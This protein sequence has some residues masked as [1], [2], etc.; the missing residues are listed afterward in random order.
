MNTILVLCLIALA[1]SLDYSIG[2]ITLQAYWSH[3]NGNSNMFGVIFGL[4][5]G[6]VIFI[7]PIVAWL[8]NKN[9]LK[10]KLVFIVGLSLNLIGN[11]IYSFAFAL[12][13]WVLILL[14]RAISGIGASALPLL[15]MYV[16]FVMDNDS[17][18]PAVGYIKYTAALTRVLGPVLGTVLALIKT[19]N[20]IFNE[21]TVTGWI[22][23]GIC[24][25]ALIVV[26]FWEEDV[27]SPTLL[28][29]DGNDNM[30][31]VT[32]IKTF[33]PIIGL[34]FITT[35]IYWYFVGNGFVIAMY[36]FHAITNSHE[37][38][39]WYYSGIGAFILA[40]VLFYFFQNFMSG[41]IG[42][43]ASSAGLI[44]TTTFFLCNI[45]VIFHF[46]VGLTTF[47]YAVLVPSINIQNNL[48][49]RKNK[50]LLGNI[51]G[52][53]IVSLAI[54]QSVARFVGPACFMLFKN[55]TE[56]AECNMTDPEYYNVSDC[57]I[58][59]Y[60]PSSIGF[61]SGSSLITMICLF[62]TVKIGISKMVPENNTVQPI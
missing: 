8:L 27:P 4:Y 50:E 12:D 49:A 19:T 15:I 38:G 9:Y 44:L 18:R 23:A 40:F 62:Y 3:V 47:C 37:L 31:Y 35:F 57:R 17:Q 36:R 58:D 43:C 7:T 2:L 28:P 13:T 21:Y 10:Y 52:I 55:V 61:I 54:F 60:I 22:P 16:A 46:A 11:V 56:S 59:G 25:I 24:L 32:I 6:F 48:L 30:D 42:L 51:A 1:L 41:N 34:G 29:Q 20:N 53:S 26:C 39:N 33:M 5:D 45:H 14:G